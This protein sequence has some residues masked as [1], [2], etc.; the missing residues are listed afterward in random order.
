MRTM[1]HFYQQDIL[2]FIA[3]NQMYPSAAGRSASRASIKVNQLE[4]IER[5]TQINNNSK[6]EKVIKTKQNEQN[7]HLTLIRLD[8]LLV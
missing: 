5:I 3:T 2:V 7:N 8:S 1:I 4:S 6:K